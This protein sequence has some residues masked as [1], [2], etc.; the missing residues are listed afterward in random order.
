MTAKQLS[1]FAKAREVWAREDPFQCPK[2]MI[3]PEKDYSITGFVYLST[4]AL[5]RVSK[6]FQVSE[7]PVSCA[8]Q[9]LVDQR[10]SVFALSTD[11]PRELSRS[12]I[13]V[14]SAGYI[15]E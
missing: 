14:L 2:P 4:D 5:G 7:P 8:L 6:C 1:S 3:C 9:W 10:P 12:Q 15:R 13:L 11:T